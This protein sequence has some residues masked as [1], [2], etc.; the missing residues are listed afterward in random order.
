MADTTA[1]L[2]AAVLRN[3]FHA[4]DENRPHILTSV[5]DAAATLEVRNRSSAIT[6]P[7]ITTGRDAIAD[8]LVRNFGQTYENVYSF[9]MNRPQGPV[10]NFSCDWLVAM[11]EKTTRNVRVGCGSYDWVFTPEPPNL[12]RRL[13]ITI[14]DMQI[15]PADRVD[16]VFTW[17]QRLTYPW[18]TPAEVVKSA[19]N[20]AELAP[21][22]QHLG[23]L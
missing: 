12:A 17:L 20:I 2:P 21:V 6:F 15:L 14:C 18:S 13:T 4:K 1:L 23:R 8:V 16:A 19:P 22:L 3:Y 5:F 7:A 9:Y 11:T 10:H